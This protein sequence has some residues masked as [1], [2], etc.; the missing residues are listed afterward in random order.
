MKNAYFGSRRRIA[1]FLMAGLGAWMCG[2]FPLHSAIH[3]MSS[4]FYCC[5]I[6][7]WI[8]TIHERI[9]HGHIR[10]YLMFGGFLMIL[11]FVLRESRWYFFAPD[12]REYASG[13]PALDR[14]LQYAY[15]VPI[16]AGALC[17]FSAAAYIGRPED[18]SGDRR[19]LPLW[20]TGGILI[21]AVLLN[22]YHHLFMMVD[23]DGIIHHRPI[24]FIVVAFAAGNVL[25]AFATAM[26]RCALSA[27]RA[28]WYIP[29]AGILIPSV[30]LIAYYIK[31]GSPT[32]GVHKLYYIHEIYSLLF[33]C[34]LEG[35]IHIGLIPSNSGYTEF[36]KEMSVDAWIDNMDGRTIYR[37]GQHEAASGARGGLAADEAQTQKH[38]RF[39]EMPIGGGSA[40][41]TENYSQVY[42]LRQEIA[43][44]IERISEE[45]TLIRYENEIKAQQAEYDARNRMFHR[46][47]GSIRPQ[48][49]RLETCIQMARQ[50]AGSERAQIAAGAVYC[51]LIKRRTNL[52]LIAS[53]NECIPLRE[54]YL[55]IR[56]VNDYLRLAEIS[57]DVRITGE[58]ETDAD[59]RTD[60]E[61]KMDAEAVI[62]VFALY[63]EAAERALESGT[64]I[65]VTIR[66]GDRFEL[67]MM[68]DTATSATDAAGAESPVT[69]S[70]A[71]AAA[72]I[73]ILKQYGFEVLQETEDSI[74][75]LTVTGRKG[76][77]S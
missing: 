30:L 77:A 48:L 57:A 9:L 2:L 8:I 10:R 5:I 15:Y 36:F 68:S 37:T 4:M 51:T 75:Y 56:E 59:K 70:A 41:W 46:I 72:A 22:D 20:M 53:E 66:V 76:G 7:A 35:C 43:E 28:R 39:R 19:I 40:H 61:V 29:A 74:S 60:G 18:E 26:H 50:S 11:L 47:A 58:G 3:R 38:L 63:S 32:V 23:P 27:A 52:E 67:R 16:I 25:A 73:L 24:Y 34:F 6:A 44:A 55:S 69:A 54:L 62:A 64:A 65:A 71:D 17:A 45:N 1:A 33:I 31:G 14:L 42:T 21:L 13:I 12:Y 49:G